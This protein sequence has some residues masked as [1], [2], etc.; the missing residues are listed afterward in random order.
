M[1]RFDEYYELSRIETPKLPEALSLPE[2]VRQSR[3][4]FYAKAGMIGIGLAIGYHEITEWINHTDV[5]AESIEASSTIT[6]QVAVTETSV[7]LL[8][9]SSTVEVLS[10]FLCT[11][12]NPDGSESQVM[13]NLNGPE[14]PVEISRILDEQNMV[15]V[16]YAGVLAYNEQTDADLA[17]IMGEGIA[18][19][20][21]SDGALT[22]SQSWGLKQFIVIENEER[23]AELGL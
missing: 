21:M 8:D 22:T 17:V 7:Q 20:D 23:H 11:I 2:P 14:T 5:Q 9:T 15:N 13:I 19:V 3:L 1:N 6:T 4:N 16:L 10:Q 18:V 12:K